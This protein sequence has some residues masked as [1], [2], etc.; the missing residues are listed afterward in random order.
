MSKRH[1]AADLAVMDQK[2]LLWVGSTLAL[3]WLFSYIMGM[4]QTLMFAFRKMIL[5][6][7]IYLLGTTILHGRGYPVATSLIGGVGLGLFSTLFLSRPA[8]T[9]RYISKK[10]KRAVLKRDLKKGDKYDSRKHHFDHT[11]PYS[12]GGDTSVRNLRLISKEKN[13]R[14]GAK[15][16]GLWDFF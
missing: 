15:Q 11:V 8:A 13:L 14:K 3:Y 10:V 9:R 16:P 7:V 1:A 2:L 4:S 12:K 5:S 6:I